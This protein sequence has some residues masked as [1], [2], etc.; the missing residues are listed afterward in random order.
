MNDY[1][2]IKCEGKFEVR[3]IYGRNVYCKSFSKERMASIHL[4][5][6]NLEGE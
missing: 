6:R 1:E 4:F 5:F 2:I 3:H